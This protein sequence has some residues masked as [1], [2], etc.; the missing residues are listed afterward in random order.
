MRKLAFLVVAAALTSVPAFAS[1]KPDV[2]PKKP[3]V[4]IYQVLQWDEPTQ[5]YKNV[6][7]ASPD[8]VTADYGERVKF[9]FDNFKGKLLIEMVTPVLDKVNRPSDDEWS[10]EAMKFTTRTS[11]KYSIIDEK[12]GERTDP[13]I[14]IEPFVELSSS[15]KGG[16]RTTLRKE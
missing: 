16:P 1:C 4:C 6:F 10:G 14:I 2:G 8:R 5:T 9:K 7:V 3:E 12:S 15:P 11:T 13:T